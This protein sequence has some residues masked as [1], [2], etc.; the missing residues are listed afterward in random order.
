MVIV[1]EDM[2]KTGEG[3]VKWEISW[4]R[5]SIFVDLEAWMNIDFLPSQ[6]TIQSV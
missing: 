6:L 4:I 5:G 1:I 3:K 2:L